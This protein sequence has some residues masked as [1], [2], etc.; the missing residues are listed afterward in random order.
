MVRKP[1]K[2]ERRPA[3]TAAAAATATLQQLP[4]V[5]IQ[6]AGSLRWS[7]P[8]SSQSQTLRQDSSAGSF[9]PTTETR[10]SRFWNY[11]SMLQ[12]S[13]QLL[14]AE[15]S[16]PPP[17]SLSLSPFSP[18]PPTSHSE[19]KWEWV[20][21]SAIRW[22]IQNIVF[23]RKC[24]RLWVGA[25]DFQ[26]QGEVSGAPIHTNLRE[27]IIEVATQVLHWWPM[28]YVLLLASQPGILL[29]NLASIS[30]TIELNQD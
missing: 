14:P 18:P 3:A 29:S 11:V 16:P 25:W 26:L 30:I 15:E 22:C 12:E 13:G 6:T 10:T 20:H 8:S 4:F 19:T 9:D 23:R 2:N 5:G 17:L 28:W 21:V 7:W 24:L 27:S 1:V